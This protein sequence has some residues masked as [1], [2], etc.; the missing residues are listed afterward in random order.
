MLLLPTL[1]EERPKER[2]GRLT[3]VSSGLALTARFANQDAEPLISSFDDPTGWNM[4]VAADRYSTSKLLGQM[5]VVKL[6][7]F[8]APDDVVVNLVDPGFVRATALDRDAQGFLK[9]IISAM[10]L[11]LGRTLKAGA[12]TY[13]DA[14][15]VKGKETHGSFLY[16][17]KVFP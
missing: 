11:V 12:W 4:S 17:W 8:V 2:P 1:K 10:K 9:I 6:K 3:I 16:N 14:A 7:D 15:V 5:F 13:I